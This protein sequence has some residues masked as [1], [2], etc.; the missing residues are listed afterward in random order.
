MG[1]PS[2]VLRNARD[3]RV[4]PIDGRV[5]PPSRPPRFETR[6]LGRAKLEGASNRGGSWLA[7]RDAFKP[8]RDAHAGRNATMH[9]AIEPRMMLLSRDDTDARGRQMPG[10]GLVVW[11]NGPGLSHRDSTQ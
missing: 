6:K 11:G 10:P 1:N 8:H 7:Q 3:P 5:T 9:R 2:S 4:V